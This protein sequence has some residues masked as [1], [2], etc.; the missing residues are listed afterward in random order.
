MKRFVAA[1]LASMLVASPAMA[2]ETRLVIRALTQDAKFIGT[3]MTGMAVTIEDADTGEILDTGITK[4]TTGDTNRILRD[5]ESR[6]RYGT[7]STEDSAKYIATLDV[8]QPRRVRV[9][10]RGP[11][12]QAQAQAEASSVRWVL[13]GKHVEQGDGWLLVVPG[14]AVDI[15]GPGAHRYVEDGSQEMEITANVIMICGCP[16]EPGGT[17]DSDHIEV[18][19]TITKDGEV[20]AS[21]PMTYAGLQ[22]TYTVTVPSA[23][24]GIYEILVTAFDARTGNSGMD[25]G[26]FI[27]R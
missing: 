6:A 14:F 15:L 2:E 18:M 4:G 27:V 19:A 16:T 24:K 23:E 1:F 21:L 20:M 22:S 10:V 17:W 25:R 7:L 9:T 26:S 13:P 5:P 11:I 12:G 8:E 3:S